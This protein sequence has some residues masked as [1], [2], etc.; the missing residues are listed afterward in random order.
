MVHAV[1]GVTLT[2][3][4]GEIVAL[5]GPSGSGKSSL[6][7]LIGLLDDPDQGYIDVDGVNVA[8][9]PGAT[10]DELRGRRM[11]FIF[12]QSHM[13]PNRNVLANVSLGLRT[14]GEPR[15]R[16]ESAAWAA[17]ERVGLRERA[18]ARSGDL[19]G[20]E[21]QRAGIARALVAEPGLVL[22]DEPTGNLDIANSLSVLELLRTVPSADRMVV[23]VTHDARVAAIADRVLTL[24]D[25]RLT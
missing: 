23:V 15:K 11:G 2:L 18:L 16:A 5:M 12:Q 3:S 1:R 20:G 7:N 19:S 8:N 21:R 22:A 10:R 9:L 6:L 25:G 17:L 24:V 4:P 14:L 13:L